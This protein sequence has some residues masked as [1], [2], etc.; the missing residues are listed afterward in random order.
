MKLVQPT[1]TITPITRAVYGLSAF[2][3]A[4]VDSC[5]AT[6]GRQVMDTMTFSGSSVFGWYTTASYRLYGQAGTLRD[7]CVES[8]YEI[9]GVTR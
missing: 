5:T 9:P 1:P 7:G 8:N 3:S 4:E 6:T 2:A